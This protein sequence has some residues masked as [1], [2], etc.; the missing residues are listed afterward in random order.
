MTRDD[1]KPFL[2]RGATLLAITCTLLFGAAVAFLLHSKRSHVSLVTVDGGTRP[3][4][5]TDSYG[6][7]NA[8][9]FDVKQTITA[10]GVTLRI[11]PLNGLSYD[12]ATISLKFASSPADVRASAMVD[13]HFDKIYHYRWSDFE[14]WWRL[15]IEDGRTSGS[16]VLHTAPTQDVAATR[17][18]AVS[19]ELDS[20]LN[21]YPVRV[22]GHVPVDFTMP[23]AAH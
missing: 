14:H 15:W 4:M 3:A 16:V 19:F 17:I 5:Y 20:M 13:S 2:R 22:T 7:Y 23:I 9:E 6:T 21:G 18:S 10:D 8:A 1:S 11:E 12:A